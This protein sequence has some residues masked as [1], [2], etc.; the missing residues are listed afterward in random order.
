MARLL[1]KLFAIV[2]F[3]LSTGLAL[4]ADLDLTPDAVLGKPNFQSANDPAASST[5]LVFPRQVTENPLS[6]ELWVSDTSGNRVLRYGS[7]ASFANGEA[8]NLVLGQADFTTKLANRGLANPAANTLSF[9][10]GLAVD[11]S[12]RLYVADSNNHRILIFQ[13]PFTNGMDAVGVLGQASLTT[14]FSN[15]GGA[16]GPATLSTPIGLALDNLGHLYVADGSNNRVLRFTAPINLLNHSASKVWGQL[17]SFSTTGVATTATG[18]FGPT[19]VTIDSSSDALWVAD[20]FNNRVLRFD[21]ATSSDATA[22]LVLCQ[23]SFTSS[24][25]PLNSAGCSQPRGVA[26]DLTGTVYV[27]DTGYH[28]VLRFTGPVF[29]GMSASAV[30]GQTSF[31]GGSSNQGV[32]VPS[33]ATLSGPVGVFLTRSSDLMVA[34]GGNG[35]LLGFDLPR[36]RA[37]PVIASISPESVPLGTGAFQLTVNGTGFYAESVV[38]WNGSPRPTTFISS[39]RLVAQIGTNDFN[40]GGSFNVTVTTPTPGG[41]NAAA[42]SISTYQTTALDS[43]ADRVLGQANFTSSLVGTQ[44]GGASVGGVSLASLG[45]PDDVAIDPT[46]GR[47]FITD[48]TYNRVLSWPS[49]SAFNNAQPADV[50]I[51]QVNG[52]GN[53]CNQGQSLA[54]KANTLCNPDGAVVDASGFLYIS[55]RTNNRV[56]GYA[57]PFTTGMAATRVFGQSGSFTT[58]FANGSLTGANNMSF[59]RGLAISGGILLVHDSNNRRILGFRTPA[60]STVADFAI[61]QPSLDTPGVAA[62]PSSTRFSSGARMAVDAQ[63]RVYTSSDLNENRVLR[64]SP[65]FSTNM[66]A[67]LVLGQ[68]DFVSIGGGTS[69]TTLLTPFGLAVDSA[70][71][72]LVADSSNNRVLRYAPPLAS[73]MAATQVMGQSTF[74]SSAFGT[75]SSRFNTP[76]GLGVTQTGDVIVT[77]FSNRRVLSFTSAFVTPV[78]LTVQKVGTGIGTVMS[79]P[80][81]IVCGATCSAG[82]VPGTSVTLTATPAAGNHFA[83]WSVS[84]CNPSLSCTVG[85]NAAM[86]VLAYF[87]QDI[88]THNL[89]VTTGGN[90]TVTSSPAGINCNATCSAGFQAGTAVTLSASPAPGYAHHGWTGGGC[91]STSLCTFTMNSS[92][93]VNAIF[94]QTFTLTV[95]SSNGTVTSSPGGISCG[96]TCSANYG[97]GTVVTLSASP[98]SGYTHTGWTGAGCGNTSQCAV[99]ISANTTVTAVYTASGRPPSDPPRLVNISTRGRVLTGA[100]VMIGGFIIGG[101]APKTVVIRANGPSLNIAGPLANPMLQLFSGQT[102][103]AANDNWQ[104]AANAATIQSSGFAPLHP[105]D[106]AIY[107]TLNPGAY[108]A[109]VTGVGGGTGVGLVEV[110]EVDL[111]SVPLINISTRGQ[112]QTGNN[113]MIAGFIIQGSGPQT[114]IV[115]ARGPSMTAQGLPGAL[116]NPMLQLFNGQTQIAVNDNWQQAANAATVQSSGFAPSDP[117]ESAI[118]VTLNPG[119]YTAIVTGVGNTTGVGIVEVFTVP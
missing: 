102:Q 42:V 60:T 55:D 25:S 48:F 24:A 40:S 72:V 114:V 82:F 68:A 27:S 52:L 29:S 50:V 7:A 62:A 17:G 3:G 91:G 95:V 49:A 4:A 51:G 18:L 35:R 110:F 75:S 38:N 39:N 115:R 33:E 19:G 12:G 79:L 67:D 20:S 54:P 93:T 88:P 26:I 45:G 31:S 117:L 109:I 22:D 5:N 105:L 111:P 9:P 15:R 47:L 56:L 94:V 92:L 13:A 97:S 2:V 112:V 28:R 46:T 61:G 90:G 80:D 83:G 30:I 118:L 98:A 59:P 71:A 81:G 32:A 44:V 87:D 57:P 116:A 36:I 6:G 63:G 89:I 73:G 16:V 76:L 119:A 41:G 23:I 64:F 65:P 69:A 70:G 11:Q 84:S 77:D 43:F 78:T 14:G 101:G 53:L 104:D 21:G 100:D 74:T 99:T 113:V 66:A 108:T 34:D 106:S 86:T 85:V 103:I 107:T 8:A 58:Q 96:S 1:G 10:E 37:L